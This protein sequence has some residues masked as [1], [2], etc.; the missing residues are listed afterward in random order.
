MNYM[1]VYF[2][3]AA[4]AVFVISMICIVLAVAVRRMAKPKTLFARRKKYD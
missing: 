4:V 1:T 3:I 2:M